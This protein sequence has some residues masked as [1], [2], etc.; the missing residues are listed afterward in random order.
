VTLS[1][2]LGTAVFYPAMVAAKSKPLKFC[3]T[4]YCLLVIMRETWTLFA[5]SAAPHCPPLLSSR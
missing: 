4:A 3:L 2:L 1:A 5:I